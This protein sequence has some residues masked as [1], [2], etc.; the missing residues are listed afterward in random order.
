MEQNAA[1]QNHIT[2]QELN[3]HVQ[4]CRTNALNKG[5]T[6]MGLKLYNKLPNKIRKVEKMRK[7]KRELRSYLLT[8][9]FYS[10]D[11]YM[12]C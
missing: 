11:E 4:V 1:I 3:L 2:C 6:N 10:V 7:F 8:H 12:S 9:T 5:V